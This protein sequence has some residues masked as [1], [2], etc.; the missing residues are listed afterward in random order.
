MEEFQGVRADKF[1]TP[2]ERTIHLP[3]CPLGGACTHPRTPRQ[4]PERAGHAIRRA[5]SEQDAIEGIAGG[6]EENRRVS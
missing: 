6:V 2:I 3:L 1:R 5:Q 4:Y